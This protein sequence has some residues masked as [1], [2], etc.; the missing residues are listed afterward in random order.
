MLNRLV[1]IAP[2]VFFCCC[3]PN[4]LKE[5]ES[6]QILIN[7]DEKKVTPSFFDLFSNLEIVPLETRQSSLISKPQKVIY[8]KNRYYIMNDNVVSIFDTKGKFIS[9]I[10]NEGRGP[11]EYGRLNDIELNKVTGDL[12]LLTLQPAAIFTYSEDEND[13]I[14]KYYLTKNLRVSKY[15]KSVSASEFLIYSS[16]AD[17]QI[18]HLDTKTDELTPLLGGIPEY[19]PTK[20]SFNPGN[21]VFFES[22][23]EICYRQVFSNKI[24]VYK[25]KSMKVKYYWDFGAYNFEIDREL[26]E[27][28]EKDFYRNYFTQND[29]KAYFFF[30]HF[31][32]DNIILTRFLF[33][34]HQN[35][36][37][38]LLDKKSKKTQL[39]DT[40]REMEIFFPSFIYSFDK[41]IFFVVN[42]SMLDQY[43]S[44]FRSLLSNEQIQE[45]ESIEIGDN[46]IIVKCF[47][48]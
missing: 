16:F 34:N 22:G 19:I 31:E 26:P 32:N 38:L 6:A 1:F 2:L 47:F 25:N 36:Q 30:D 10:D 11:N 48:K 18:Y 23:E 41:G 45:F 4:K 20:T 13:I 8:G 15:F 5:E 44:G 37:S 17:N 42:R 39:F 14:D 27:G 43:A 9:K 46:P 3:A 29:T 7:L 40:F 24:Y 21:T 28:K 12:E 35:Y 33:K